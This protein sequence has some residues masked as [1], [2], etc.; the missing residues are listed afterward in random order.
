MGFGGMPVRSWEWSASR[1]RAAVSW[2]VVML[3]QLAYFLAVAGT[4]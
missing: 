3:D 2:L 1:R 4:K